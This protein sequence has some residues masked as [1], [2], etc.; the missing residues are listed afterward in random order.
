GEFLF[1]YLK[2]PVDYVKF[3]INNSNAP[4]DRNFELNSKTAKCLVIIV[5]SGKGKVK[6]STL[7]LF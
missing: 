4:L 1:N 2:N 3:E 7:K 5:N 6:V